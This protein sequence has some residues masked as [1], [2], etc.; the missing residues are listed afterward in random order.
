LEQDTLYSIVL[1]FVILKR[2]TARELVDW[3]IELKD[4]RL[5]IAAHNII[6]DKL[7]LDPELLPLEALLVAMLYPTLSL[8]DLIA[9]LK[10]EGAN[11]DSDS[12]RSTTDDI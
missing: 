5:A 1:R 11:D 7:T 9:D 6:G 8:E 2:P 3:M 12:A 10:E 4:Q